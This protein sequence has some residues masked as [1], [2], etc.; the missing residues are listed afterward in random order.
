MLFEHYASG[1]R[2]CA[3]ANATAAFHDCMLAAMSAAEA[4]DHADALLRPL[5]ML[6][7]V[8]AAM[9]SIAAC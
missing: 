9:L 7:A 1:Q 6:F 8:D 5:L 2:N 4:F 3:D